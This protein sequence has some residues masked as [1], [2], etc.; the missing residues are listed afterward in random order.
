[1][2]ESVSAWAALISW[3]PQWV[4]TGVENY[5]PQNIVNSSCRKSLSCNNTRQFVGILVKE[6]KR[7]ISLKLAETSAFRRDQMLRTAQTLARS[8]SQ[9]Q[10]REARQAPGMQD[11]L[12]SPT[13]MG[14]ACRAPSRLQTPI[15]CPCPVRSRTNKKP[16]TSCRGGSFEYSRPRRLRLKLLR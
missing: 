5:A 1:M 7:G 8:R 12:P 15:V 6:K 13:G 4:L 14:R 3:P 2:I 16:A 9:P 10:L 11:E